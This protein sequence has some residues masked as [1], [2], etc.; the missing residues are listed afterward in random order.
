MCDLRWRQREWQMRSWQVADS[1]KTGKLVSDARCFR[2]RRVDFEHREAN[3]KNGAAFGPVV[4]SD[5]PLVVL[6]YA[7]GGAESETGAFA[8]RLGGVERIEAALGIAQAGAG[9]GELHDHFVV[10]APET[11][12]ETPASGFLQC[13][14]RVFDN[15]KKGLQELVGVAQD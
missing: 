13:V 14:H 4:A 7:V 3:F 2:E 6:N 9:V 15:L 10:L 5:L 8:N 11:Y 12:L 1:V